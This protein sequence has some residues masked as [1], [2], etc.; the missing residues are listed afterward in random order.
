M[1]PLFRDLKPSIGR[2]LADAM[3]EVAVS[4]KPAPRQN[5]IQGLSASGRHYGP[6]MGAAEAVVVQRVGRILRQRACLHAAR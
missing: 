6:R 5:W 3:I 4:A 1:Q 2:T